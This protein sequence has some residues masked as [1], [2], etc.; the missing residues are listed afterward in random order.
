MAAF[1]T[2]PPP[3]LR[4]P[5]ATSVSL[6]P[7]AF[8]A[9]S[10]GS[11]HLAF[12][13][14]SPSRDEAQPI[15]S[16]RIGVRTVLKSSIADAPS[17]TATS[18]QVHKFG[19]SSVGTA[20]C[21]SNVA[22]L[23][24]A[25]SADMR[26]FVVLSAV[27]GVTDMLLSMIDSAVNRS[28][29]THYLEELAA[30]HE[31][32]IAL[33]E[34]LLPESSR[35]VVLSGLAAD[36]RD[37]K[38]LLRACWIARSASTRVQDL[39][40]GHGELWS[41]QLLWA[42]LRQKG[43]S[44]AIAWMDARDVL[45]A[46]ESEGRGKKKVVCFDDSRAKLT[47][48]VRSNP[49]DFVVATGF[50]CQD[51]EG[52]PSTLGRNGSDYSAAAFANLLGAESLQI[53]TDVD[54]VYSADPR[55][56]DDA[57]VI[58]SLSYKEAAEFAYFGAKV[59]HPDT[60][61]PVIDS[62]IP[63]RIRNTFNVSAPGTLVR[64][65]NDEDTDKAQP[66]KRGLGLPALKPDARGVK[67]FTTVSDVSLVNI[68]GTG[69]IG[70]PGIAS[71]A[72]QALYSAGVSVILIAQAS[73]EYSIC[74]AVPSTQD[75]L[76]VAS[77]KTAFRVE[78][79]DGLVSSVSAIPDSS[80][81]AM[82]GEQMQ[83]RPGVS[84]RLFASLTRAGVNIRAMAQGSSERNISV[85][86][87]SASESRAVRAAHASF[88]LSD[89][90]ISV[91]VIGPGV[92]GSVLLAQ[93]HDQ[94]ESLR[95]D[96]G[97]DLRVRGIATSSKMLLGDAIDL[98]T[99]RDDMSSG[100]GVKPMDMEAFASHIQ[101]SALPH[102]VICDCTASAV[103]SDFYE[104]WL[105]R[106]IHI[107]TPNKKANSGPQE[108]YLAM[109]EAQRRLN[110]HFFYEANVGA[111][112]PIISS[113]RELLRTG[114][115]FLEIEGIF[116]GTLSYIFNSFDGSEPFSS[117]VKRAKELGYT[118]PD[119]R[120]DLNGADVA[121][122]V[123]ILAR[124]VGLDIELDDVPVKSLVPAELSGDD[125]SVDEFLERLPNSDAELTKMA[126]EAKEAGELLRYVGF[127]RPATGECGV[128][129]KRY[130]EEHPFGRLKGSD[131]I[132]SFRTARYDAQPLVVQGPGAGAD[133]T[134]RGLWF[135][136]EID[137]RQLFSLTG[138]PEPVLTCFVF[139]F[140]P[141]YF[142]MD[143]RGL[144]Y[145]RRPPVCLVTFSSLLPTLEHLPRQNWVS[146][147]V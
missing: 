7:S 120:D 67:G 64:A 32:H 73:S 62:S 101:S 15:S 122:K 48:W 37:L 22:D 8:V 29:G 38:D 85:V 24:L 23:M 54:G 125:V 92:V 140:S 46:R 70:V 61:A 47:D 141:A 127:V 113:I 42:V 109:R 5:V 36:V 130:S 93:I 34:E 44:R 69:M 1:S 57:I 112:L 6:A 147:G 74:A 91:G 81:L 13:P 21:I 28:S 99:W 88:Y 128:E 142:C 135:C 131:N 58:P 76:A 89:Q 123:V 104:P 97:V 56:V 52:V 51:L 114:D 11:R 66:G 102:A 144:F 146:L 63:M 72:F 25:D 84:S 68:E 41:A 132:V 26:R 35:S 103:V 134:V 49:V 27:G 79:D 19:G 31:K 71:R 80:I 133:V 33:V 3:L 2:P 20:S 94:I 145:H 18:W 30:I 117:V 55:V 86:V 143:V 65:S 119:C 107:I 45:V 77:L 43:G 50:I 106:G 110:T 17:A 16:A 95:A 116:S 98:E 111:G 78:L 75:T 9:S 53:W 121:R 90:T 96:F 124:E 83:Q 138:L 12:F 137:S 4:V 129:L 60:M 10:R 136:C 118:E 40:V 87:D 39:I 100:E 139:R 108:Y 14:V 105:Q 126:S 115:K 59:L 82:V